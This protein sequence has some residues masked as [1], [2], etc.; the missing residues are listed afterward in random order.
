MVDWSD[1]EFQKSLVISI[2]G[3]SV[4]VWWISSRIRAK[5]MEVEERR[6]KRWQETDEFSEE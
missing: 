1:S 5:L 4:G 3:L 6:A 2:I